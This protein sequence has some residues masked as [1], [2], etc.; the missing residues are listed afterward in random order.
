MS[1]RRSAIRS[2]ENRVEKHVGFKSPLMSVRSITPLNDMM[3][4]DTFRS[5]TR[6]QQQPPNPS[7]TPKRPLSNT[8]AQGGT[9]VKQRRAPVESDPLPLS[10]ATLDDAV[11]KNTLRVQ[12]INEKINGLF[13]QIPT[14]FEG[15]NSTF[16]KTSGIVLK[17]HTLDNVMFNYNEKEKE[18]TRT[19]NKLLRDLDD[20]DELDLSLIEL[21]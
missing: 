19:L 10:N 20:A 7:P 4:S 5:P 17:L 21:S 1:D 12:T 13:D 3:Q 18:A 9:P 8:P 15:A 14:I 2:Q 6:V 11:V 16:N